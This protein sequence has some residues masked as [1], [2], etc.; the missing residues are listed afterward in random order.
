MNEGLGSSL[1]IC[2]FISTINNLDKKV[3][4]Y[5]AQSVGNNYLCG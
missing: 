4:G 2:K 5:E 3:A 1:M